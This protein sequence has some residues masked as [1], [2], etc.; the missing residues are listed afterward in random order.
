MDLTQFL[1]LV[2][3]R[4]VDRY[5]AIRELILQNLDISQVVNILSISRYH[6]SP[7]EFKR[8][9][10]YNCIDKGITIVSLGTPLWSFPTERSLINV[11]HRLFYNNI[12]EHL[13]TWFEN[14]INSDGPF[15]TIFNTTSS[16]S[17]FRFYLEASS[18]MQYQPPAYNTTAGYVRFGYTIYSKKQPHKTMVDM[19]SDAQHN[20][21]R[22]PITAETKA[23]FYAD[24]TYIMQSFCEYLYMDVTDFEKVFKD[25][26]MKQ[27]SYMTEEDFYAQD[28]EF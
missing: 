24:V 2:F 8:Y 28:H 5:P 10:R 25:N 22:L 1:S 17:Q 19:F 27:N 6:C 15:I 12:R 7:T 16:N 21:V 14:I 11:F 4:D 13:F 26:I 23:R 20:M 9:I 3:D 18:S